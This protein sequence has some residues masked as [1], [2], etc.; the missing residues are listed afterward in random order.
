MD[1]FFMGDFVVDLRTSSSCF[2]TS[3]C[4][5]DR[6]CRAMGYNPTPRAIS[7]RVTPMII[8]AA[9]SWVAQNILN[10]PSFVFPP[11]KRLLFHGANVANP[12]IGRCVEHFMRGGIPQD[13]GRIVS[14][15]VLIA[16]N[17]E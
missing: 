11:F 14:T 4:R 15:V 3:N 5:S 17:A 8:A 6:R 7:S 9:H 12:G 1:L 16:E 13:N 10:L 2:W